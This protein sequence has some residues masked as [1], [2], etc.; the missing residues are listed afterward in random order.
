[1]PPDH[2]VGQPQHLSQRPDFV[3]EKSAEWLDQ[4]EPEFRREAADVVVV[5][6]RSRRPVWIASAFNHVG[7]KRP[8][9]QEVGVGNPPGLFAEDP[10]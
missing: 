2:L 9:R 1:M 5:L 4:L 6:D 3:L 10:R 8:L 7:V